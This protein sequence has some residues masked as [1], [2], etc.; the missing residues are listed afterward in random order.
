MTGLWLG[1][2]LGTSGLR[3]AVVDAG[4]AVVAEA[5]ATYGAAPESDAERWWTGACDCLKAQTE[6]LREARY[7]PSDIVGL[8]VDG[9]SGSMVLA[10]ADL[11][12]VTPALMYHTG[13]FTE[14]AARIDLVAP[15]S[16][17]T[18]G[19]GSAL[20]RA[21]RL[22]S[23]DT[24]TRARYLLHQADFVLARLSGQGGWSDENNTL[25]L[26]FDP[27]TGRWPDWF[28]A[29]G[30]R[31]DLLP[32]VVP[33]GRMIGTVAV[34]VA[35]QLGLSSDTSIHAGTTDSLAAFLACAPMAAGVAVTSLGTTLALKLVSDKRIDAPEYGLYSHRLSG[36]WLVGGA[37]NTGGG[38]LA[39][40]FDADALTRLSERI[41]ASVESP[42][43]YYPLR[44]PG[45]RFPINDPTLQPRLDPR[46]DDDVAYLHGLLESIAR[47]ERAGYRCIS[48]L[49]GSMPTKIFT[50]GG[51]AHNVPWAKIR[52]RVLG[53]PIDTAPTTEASVGAARLALMNGLR[54]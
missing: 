48:D 49:G 9:T 4:G 19:V 47:I 50:A 51:G 24:D 34:D 25:K 53:V 26:G 46:P 42:L 16:H 23:F 30:L 40:L 12:P 6:T 43:D 54:G 32:N 31:T 1:L 27:E 10:D 52:R 5:R 39:D 44:K 2:D 35:S 7:T 14:E 21:L 8:C 22:Q 11:A 18:R 3:S 33:A 17:I 37:S 45:E 20:A 28:A 15:T 38:V 29:T 36:H 13:D 41:D